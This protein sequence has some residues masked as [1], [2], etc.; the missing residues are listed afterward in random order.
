MQKFSLILILTFFFLLNSISSSPLKD[1]TVYEIDQNIVG[2][3]EYKTKTVSFQASD[4]IYYLKYDFGSKVPSSLTTAFKLDFTPYSYEMNNYKIY[5][6]NV[7]SSA[8][9]SD[10]ISS[11]QEV[12]ADE[13]KSSCITI[14][15]NHG[16]HDSLMKLDNTKTKI[17]IAVYIPANI[18][19]EVKIN[20]RIT[21]RA[22][23]VN[24][25]KPSFDETYSIIPISIEIE[26]FRAIP[27]SKILFYSSTRDLQMYETVSSVNFPTELFSGNILNVYTNPNMVR[28]K[29]HN[30]KIMTLLAIPYEI[31]TLA[32]NFKFQVVL[33]ESSFLLDYYVSSNPDGRSLNSPLLINMTDCSNPYYVILNYNAH[34]YGKTL[35]LDEIYGKLSYLGLASNLESET[36][37][38]MIEKD[39]ISLSLNE[40]KYDLPI[41]SSNMDVYKIQCTLPIMLNFYY[42]DTTSPVYTM[43]EGDVQI[44]NLKPY[45]TINVP[46][47]SGISSPEI[48]I[49]INQPENNPYIII[50]VTQDNVFKENT[51]ERYVPLTLNDGI[52]IIRTC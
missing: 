51:L 28:Q 52:T 46:F 45:Q 24:E 39:I 44:F 13:S 26:K 11:L 49:E 23:A 3:T 42:I 1:G 47:D 40:K 12:K 16:Y 37:E 33:F 50:R 27:K 43:K 6:T 14:S 9:D 15:Q 18:G 35:V 36:W 21:E 17:G 32:E 4:T 41:S 48:L 29:Y 8:S 2:T 38:E 5:C 30:A 7:L 25:E 10:L 31:K 20:L 34:D 19:T 22:L